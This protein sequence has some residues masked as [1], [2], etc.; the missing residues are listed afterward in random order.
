MKIQLLIKQFNCE[1]VGEFKTPI[2]PI[3]FI[4]IS[5]QLLEQH[6]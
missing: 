5:L 3:G 4:V 1:S 6:C 2:G